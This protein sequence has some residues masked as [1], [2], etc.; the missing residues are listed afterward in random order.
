[1]KKKLLPLLA[2][3]MLSFQSASAQ[4]RLHFISEYGYFV[5]AGTETGLPDLVPAGD[6][7]I[8]SA[9]PKGYVRPTEV[10]VWVVDNNGVASEPITIQ[11]GATAGVYTIPASAMQG[12]EVYI[13][14]EFKRKN[15]QYADDEY[16]LIF[17]DEFDGDD[18]SQP[19]SD[20]WKR[21]DHNNN[22]TWNRF[23]STSD[24]VVYIE[25]GD[26]VTR[27]IPCPEEDWESNKN[28]I[29]PYNYRE[30]MSGAV[31]TRTKFS[32]TYGRVDVR[33]KTNPFAGSF[34][35][36]WMIPDDQSAGWPQYGEIDIWEMV[37]TGNTAYGT[38]HAQRESQYSR[39]TPCNYDGLYHVFTF[40]WDKDGMSWAIDGKTYSTH[41][42]ASYNANQLAQGFW[43]FDKDYYLILN[44]SVGA[45]GWAA[46]PVAGHTYETRFDFVRIYQTREQNPTVGMRD[47]RAAAPAE[48]RV[49]DLSGRQH[50]DTTIL[51]AGVY[52]RD[53]K[54]FVVK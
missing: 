31:D 18:H 20:R 42:K 27:C 32:F 50:P 39:N 15:E 24:K 45:G 33:A 3:M 36:I 52:I 41:K 38:I 23:V 51:P 29:S 5:G 17:G 4:H 8:K 2:S 12:G 48:G 6:L 43:P 10:S 13:K 21:A 30:W 35:A 53:G 49:F 9:I 14:G 16:Q 1:M 37:N 25:D 26:L 28:T 22:S 54:K 34:P 47:L 46:N 19:N 7:T 40:I 44:Q 11:Q